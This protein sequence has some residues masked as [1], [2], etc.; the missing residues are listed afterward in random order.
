MVVQKKHET[1]PVYQLKISLDGIK[2]PIWRRIL[3]RGDVSLFKLHKSFRRRWDGRN[4][5]CINS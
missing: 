5:I 1:V 3:V 4:I 2:P